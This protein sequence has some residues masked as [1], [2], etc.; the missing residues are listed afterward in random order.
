MRTRYVKNIA[1]IHTNRAM[2]KDVVWIALQDE[3]CFCLTRSHMLGTLGQLIY[4]YCTESA[5]INVAVLMWQYASRSGLYW[6]VGTGLYTVSAM[7]GFYTWSRLQPNTFSSSESRSEMQV[8][9][10]PREA[11]LK[12]TSCL[13]SSFYTLLFMACHVPNSTLRKGPSLTLLSPTLGQ[14]LVLTCCLTSQLT[15]DRELLWAQSLANKI[16]ATLLYGHGWIA[17]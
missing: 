5:V 9:E 12:K 4:L 13:K 16:L 2:L 15:K 8:V 11:L 3:R 10:I 14:L 1:A 17:F 7:V 6:F